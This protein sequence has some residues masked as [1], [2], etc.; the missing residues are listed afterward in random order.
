M[1]T[2]I[3]SAEEIAELINETRRLEN[4]YG[5]SY[6]VVTHLSEVTASL[7]HTHR[8]A[9]KEIADAKQAGWDAAMRYLAELESWQSGTDRSRAKYPRPVAADYLN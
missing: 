5:D 7:Q 9:Q 6:E 2:Q 3:A 4:D 1:T 8:E